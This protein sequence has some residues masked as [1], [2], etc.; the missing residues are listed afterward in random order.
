MKKEDVISTLQY[1]NLINYYKVRDRPYQFIQKYFP[2]GGYFFQVMECFAV[3][4]GT[5]GKLLQLKEIS[6]IVDKTQQK[7][8]VSDL[9]IRMKSTF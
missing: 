8:W 4:V 9:N 7:I 6:K 3:L 1:L 5:G 2:L